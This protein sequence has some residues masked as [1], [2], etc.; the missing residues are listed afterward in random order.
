MQ[1]RMPV[2]HAPLGNFDFVQ[3][4][5]DLGRS[6][7]LRVWMF[8]QSMSKLAQAFG[9]ENYR[10]IIGNCLVRCFMRPD[11]EA[12]ELL[13]KPI[14]EVHN[15]FSGERRP[16]ATV[17][18]LMGAAYGDKIIVTTSGDTPMV[19]EKQIAVEAFPEKM[20]RPD[21]VIRR[22]PPVGKPQKPE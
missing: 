14:G 3:L 16:L 19:L 8:A 9:R 18:D 22:Q 5:Q 10:G 12:A 4:L 20:L 2:E 6:S 11:D 21:T 1:E 17:S 15:P 13:S 7:G